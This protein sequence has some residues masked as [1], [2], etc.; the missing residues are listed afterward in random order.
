MTDRRLSHRVHPVTEV[1]FDFEHV[2]A[3]CEHFSKRKRMRVKF[4]GCAL[5]PHVD[6]ETFGGQ[7][8]ERFPA[9]VKW[10]KK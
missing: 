9:C 10:R 2:C 1:E 4:I 8:R 7:N 6:G 3:T 5:A